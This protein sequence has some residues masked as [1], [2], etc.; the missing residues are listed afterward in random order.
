MRHE[1]VCIAGRT[2]SES[3]FVKLA[4]GLVDD[5]SPRVR[6]ALGDALRRVPATESP[7]VLLMMRLGRAPL[8]GGDAWDGY[9]RQLERFLARWAMENH[10]PLVAQTLA[11]AAGAALPIEN[12]ALATLALGSP[13]AAAG[14]VDLIPQ[15]DRPLSEEEIRVLCSSLDDARVA[16]ALSQLAEQPSSRIAVLQSLLRLRTS[17]N[18]PQLRGLVLGAVQTLWAEDASPGGRRLALEAIGAF[19]FHELE[20]AALQFICAAETPR[21][22]RLSGLRTLRELGVRDDGQLLALARQMKSDPDVRSAAIAALAAAPRAS[23]GRSLLAAWDDF[24]LQEHA[25]IIDRLSAHRGGAEAILQAIDDGTLEADDLPVADLQQ[26]RELLPNNRAVEQLWS[27]IAGR[28]HRVLRL[29][30]TPGDSGDKVSLV[31]PFTVET[32]AQLLPEID[33]RDSLLSAHGQMNVNF[34]DRRLRVYIGDR[35]LVIA[36]FRTLPEVWTHYA[37]TRDGQGFFS[38]YV[39]GEL[40]SR[41]TQPEPRELHGLRVGFGLVPRSGTDA[42][43]TEFRVWNVALGPQQIRDNFDRSFAGATHPPGLVKLFTE[44][45]W[46]QLQGHARL[47]PSLDFPPLVSETQAAARAKKF[48]HFRQLAEQPGDAAAGRAL[49]AKRCL[50]C[51]QQAGQGGKIGPALDGVGLHT[52]EA[53]LR[54]L[55][56]PSAAMEGGYRSFRVLTKDGRVLQGLLVSRDADAIVLRQVDTADLKLS[57]SDLMRAE[58]TNQSVMPD[59]LLESLTPREVADLFAYI[60]TLNRK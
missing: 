58:F 59:G 11:S 38:L 8:A 30:G 46:G 34:F 60:R 48:A 14:L 21:G 28:V 33:N 5:P 23:A 29:T 26:M 24:N 42:R 4:Q 10:A 3:D 45:D 53:L 15:L 35:D 52:T 27:E 2:C 1:A 37:I 17:L 36:R 22:L 12:R 25:L 43:F 40:D 56:T 19:G 18:A 9:D 20:S 54:N 57:T 7:T 6:A 49:F 41:S 31:G 55:L 39:N 51:H 13:A 47:E 32:W 44:A 16:Q 50:V